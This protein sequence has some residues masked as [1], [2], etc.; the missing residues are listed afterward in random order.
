MTTRTKE[1]SVALRSREPDY[2]DILI[3]VIRSAAC[4][5]QL[6]SLEQRRRCKSYVEYVLKSPFAIE[7]WRARVSY[8]SFGSC[9]FAEKQDCSISATRQDMS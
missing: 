4:Y 5:Q 2:V 1:S 7:T 8:A 3:T 9:S 6:C